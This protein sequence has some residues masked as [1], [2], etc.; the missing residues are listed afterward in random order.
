MRPPA[1]FWLALLVLLFLGLALVYPLGRIVALGLGEGLG[2]ALTD[3][4]YLSRLAWSLAYGTGSALLC[5]GLA[6]PLAYLF[7]YRFPGRGFWL[8][9]STVPLVLPTLAVALGFLALLGPQGPLGLNLY[10]TPWALFWAAVLYNLGLVLRPLVALLPS[11]GRL[12][13]TA[14]TLGAHPLRAYLRVGVPVLFPALLSGGSLVFLFCFTSFGVPLLLGGPEWATLEV[15]TYYA[16][17]QRLAFPEASA[18]VLMQLGV[19]L[20]VIL[21]Y[22]WLQTRLSVG[23]EGA[24][25]PLPLPPGRAWGVGVG[26]GLFLGLLYS[27]LLAL[28]WRALERPSAWL[29]VWRSLEFTPGTQALGN[30]LAFAGLALLP[31]LTLGVLYAYAVWRGA[32]WLDGLGLLPLMVSPVAVG[33]GYLLA[34]P[35]QR[36]SLLLLIGAYTLLSY[37]L[38]ARSLLPALQGLPRGT[39]EAARVLGA[40]PWRRFFRVEWPLVRPS[41]LAGLGLA[42][43]AV[44]GEFGATLTLQRPEWTTLS[45]AIYERLGRPGA[46]PFYEAMVLAVVLMGLCTALVLGLQRE[47]LS[48]PSSGPHL[49]PLK[50]HVGQGKKQKGKRD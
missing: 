32:G 4:Y 1:P 31:I 35:G 6:V 8:A 10:G 42:L 2:A 18:L 29:S 40:S 26:V 15:A 49:P 3:P 30:T 28:L 47:P 9:F 21:G 33:L 24:E 36:G 50:E 27:P 17:A 14:R 25:A 13:M 7:R 41:A 48:S 22:T 19:T 16:L 12:L 34:Y 20:V 38:L 43:A 44:L 39:L 46:L 11:V 23:L 5:I 37:P 45:L